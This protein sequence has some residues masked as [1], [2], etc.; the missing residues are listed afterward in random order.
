[1]KLLSVIGTRPQYVKASAILH[2]MKNYP[3]ITNVLVDSGQ[4]YD[5]N[6]S[7]VFLD[8]L[9]I[10]RPDYNLQ[11]GSQ[12]H[13]KMTAGIMIGVDDIIAKEKPDWVLVY[14]DTNTTLGAALAAAKLNIP[15]AHIEA[16]IR[17]GNRAMPEEINRILTDHASTLLFVPTK[18]GIDQLASEGIT[19]K[20]VVYAGD[21]MYDVAIRFKQLAKEKSKILKTLELEDTPFIAST[22]H[23]A[24]NTD[25]LAKLTAIVES[26]CA[27]ANEYRIVL[28]L[29]PRTRNAL[30]KAGLYDTLN[31]A[32]TLTEPLGYLDMAMLAS[33]AKL[34]AT[35]SGGLQ[36]EAFFYRVPCVNVHTDVFWPELVDMGWNHVAGKVTQQQV[37]ATIRKALAQG[38]PANWS[39]PFGTDN[40]AKTIL[41]ALVNY[42]A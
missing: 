4:H 32:I 20:R 27:L 5:A 11:V 30:I 18:R 2:E 13:A 7:D 34:V 17:V 39:N 41:D 12:S 9:S 25:D 19:G 14:G 16:G 42:K 21:V 22:I 23:R 40:N 3:Q 29:H 6:L 33:H 26:F 28:P 37:T 10:P 36:R 1:M 31:S 15:V 24:E 8:E 35:D 38:A